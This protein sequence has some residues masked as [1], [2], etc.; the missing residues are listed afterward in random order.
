MA[1]GQCPPYKSEEESGR[2]EGWK[3]GRKTSVVAC[4]EWFMICDLRS[5]KELERDRNSFSAFTGH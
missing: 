3:D 5:A 2:A 1:G 4:E